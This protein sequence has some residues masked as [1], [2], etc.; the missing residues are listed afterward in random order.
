MRA[1]HVVVCADGLRTPQLLFASGVRPPALG[2]HL[3]EHLQMVSF[4][5]LNDEFSPGAF[6][7]DTAYGYVLVPFSDERPIQGRAMAL[8]SSPFRAAFVDQPGSSRLGM[9]AWYGSKDLQ[10]DDA[11]E[12][13]ETETDCYGMPRMS[14]RYRFTERDL[15][16][17]EEMRRLSLRSAAVIG[18][19]AEEPALATGGASLHYQG[20]VRMGETDDGSSVCDEHLRVWGVDN[21]YVGGNGVIPTSTASNPTLTTVALAW[22]AA[23]RVAS[24]LAAPTD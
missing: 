1:T 11:V 18:T 17:I 19:L 4:V 6:P 21:L 22:R 5:R 20:T 10:P 16:T 15:A 13:S 7:G 14:I 12:L 3:N 9:V 2:R 8:A 24:A 23:C